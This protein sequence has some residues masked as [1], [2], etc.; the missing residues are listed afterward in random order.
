MCLRPEKF[1][2]SGELSMVLTLRM[3]VYHTVRDVGGHLLP[4]DH[5][6]VAVISLELSEHLL[7]LEVWC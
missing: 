3:V 2:H 1:E 6:N 7:V 5:S 4:S